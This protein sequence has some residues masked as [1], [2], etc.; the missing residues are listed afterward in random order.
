MII[1]IPNNGGWNATP[2]GLKDDS[3]FAVFEECHPFGIK[4]RNKKA[5]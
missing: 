1:F 5:L 4:Y 3:G 2:S